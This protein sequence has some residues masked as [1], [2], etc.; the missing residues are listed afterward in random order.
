MKRIT[1]YL[2]VCACALVT[3]AWAFEPM[4][5]TPLSCEVGSW[6]SSVCAGYLNGD[7]YGDLV[8]AND[9]SDNI[10]VLLGNGDGTF[11]GAV[12]YG[13]G[14]RPGSICTSDLN[15]KGS[16]DIAV[17]NLGSYGMSGGDVSIL[18]NNGDGILAISCRIA[19]GWCSIS[20][21]QRAG[22][23]LVSSMR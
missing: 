10:S 2:A 4:F 21:I 1:V 23:S 15:G 14:D 17:V 16:M 6:P 19:R 7:G 22:G 12:H 8:A 18:L 13:V 5:D 9:N 3:Q 20:S 11:A